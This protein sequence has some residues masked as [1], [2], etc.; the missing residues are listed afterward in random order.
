MRIFGPSIV[1]VTALTGA[2]AF[3]AC[4][5]SPPKL[6]GQTP[7]PPS[8]YVASSGSEKV[9]NVTAPA[10]PAAS[11]TFPL[12]D[13]EL[14]KIVNPSG[15]TEYTGPTGVI[16]GTIKVSGDPPVVKTFTTLPN[17]CA[18]AQELH[19]PAY[20]K[21]KD[22]ELADALVGV[23]GVS[24]YVRPSRDDKTVHVHDCA[25]EPT[26]ID[27]S[28]GQRLMV[29]NDDDQPFM[30]QVAM[31][32]IVRRVLMKGM[33]ASP[34][35]LTQ[36]GAFA[37]SWFLA[38]PPNPEI[39]TATIFVLPSA[40][41]DVTALDGKFRIANVPVGKA[42]VTASHV[43]MGEAFKDVEVKPGET[44]K[45]DLALTYKAPPPTTAPSMIPSNKLPK[46]K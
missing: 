6:D 46:I 8:G 26:V 24:G 2:F 25:I 29:L 21:G 9:V 5:E 12:S 38:E 39:P 18:H 11:E 23:I 1:V 13:D 44:L 22:G 36:P 16:E 37:M 34:L 17:G 42:R 19:G 14:R 27:L 15:A 32:M 45:V 35:L 33:P 10:T 40:L 3:A 20:R 41:H 31:K 28:L 30:P 4:K 7:T 43:G